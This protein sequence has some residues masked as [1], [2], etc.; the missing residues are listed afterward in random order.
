MSLVQPN[1]IAWI[2]LDE[3]NLCDRLKVD[4]ASFSAV[5]ETLAA[6]HSVELSSVAV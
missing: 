4:T 3:T 2:K 1:A 6:L 5:G